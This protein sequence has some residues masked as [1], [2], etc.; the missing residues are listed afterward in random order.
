V[1]VRNISGHRYDLQE[2]LGQ[3]LRD[4]N[5]VLSSL[6]V[7]TIGDVTIVTTAVEINARIAAV[8]LPIQADYP[9]TTDHRLRQRKRRRKPPQEVYRIHYCLDACGFSSIAVPVIGEVLIFG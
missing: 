1:T 2:A 7:P 4:W 9:G 5:L 8:S 3:R 6:L